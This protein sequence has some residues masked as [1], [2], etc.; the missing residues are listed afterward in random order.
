M[1]NTAD[2]VWDSMRPMVPLLESIP[3][4]LAW[5][6]G[7]SPPVLLVMESNA[8]PEMSKTSTRP[9]PVMVTDTGEFPCSRTG[10]WR[11]RQGLAGRRIHR[12]GGQR[13]GVAAVADIDLADLRGLVGR[14]ARGHNAQAAGRFDID[15]G[16]NR[17][18]LRCHSGDGQRVGGIGRR[19][20][21]D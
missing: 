8:P 14:A 21:H 18:C 20:L 15:D 10:R 16:G 9:W 1:G 6:V 12:R 5:M 2:A 11:Q 3:I 13:H 7:N 4:E 17:R 19:Q